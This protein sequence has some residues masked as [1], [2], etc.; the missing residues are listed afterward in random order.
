M[1]DLLTALAGAVILVL[2]AALALPPF[3][4]WTARRAFVDRAVSRSLGMAA[5]SEGEIAVR[6]LPSP[7]LR[8]DRLVLGQEGSL[9]LDARFVKAEVALTPLLKGEFRFT[10]T[11][12]GRAELTV[13]VTEGNALALPPDLAEGTRRDLV[14]EDLQVQQ[15]AVTTQVPAT[16]RTDQIRAEDVHLK[17]PALS[18]P[19]Q[20]EGSSNGTPFRVATGALG[21]DGSLTAKVTG[22]GETRPRFEADARFSLRPV[23]GAAEGVAM[24]EAEGS[25]R[26]VVGPPSQIAGPYLPFSLTGKF[27]ARGPVARFETVAA[28]IDPGGR[29]MRLSGTGQIDLRTWRAGLNLEARRLDI[30]GFLISSA[31]QAWLARGLPKTGLALPVLLDL[32][33]A[34]DSVAL[35]LEEWSGLALKGTFDRGGGLVLRR[36]TATGPGGARLDASGEA[37]LAQALRFSGHLDVEAVNSANLGRFL[38]RA[39][40]P[41]TLANLLDGRTLGLATD[42]SLAG[43]D[44]SLSNLRL[45]LGDLRLAGNARYAAGAPNGRGR[46]EAQISAHGL[47]IAEL[48]SLGALRAGLRRSDLGLTIQARDVRYGPTGSG[49]GRIAARIQSDGTALVVDSL[50][51]TDLAGASARLSGRIAPDGSGRIAGH[52]AAPAAAPLLALVDRFGIPEMRLL[53]NVLRESPLD[54]DLT[55][56]RAAGDTDSL[57]IAAKGK[58]ARG[59]LDGAA[60]SR[61]GRI[62]SAEIDAATPRASDWFGRDDI[63]ALRQPGRLRIA[64]RRVPDAPPAPGAPKPE[65]AGLLGLSLGGNLAGLALST[66]RPILLADD[67]SAPENGTIGIET[68]DLTPFLTLAGS[69]LALS[70]PLR[71]KLTLALS[72]KERDARADLSGRVAGVPLSASLSRSYDGALTG[73]ASL[74]RLSLPLLAAALILPT[75]PGAA[76][77][78]AGWSTARFAAPPPTPRMA[79]DLQVG[80]LDLGRGLTARNGTFHLAHEGETLTLRD[81]SAD[82][83]GGKLSGGL[84]L[85]PLPKGASL[86]GEATLT[87]AALPDLVGEGPLKG[88][89]SGDLRFSS[90]GESPAALVGNLAGE[91][92]LTLA[93]LSLPGADPAAIDRTLARAL[94]EDDPLREG[95]LQGLLAEELSAGALTQAEP[96]TTST[97]LVGGSLRSAPLTLALGPARW[98]GTLGIDLRSRRLDARGTLVSAGAPKGWPGAAPAIQ[99]GFAGPL[100]APERQTDPAPLT[101]GLAAL[102]L[103]RELEKIEMF[104]ADQVERQRRRA[105]IEM[106][107]ARAAALKAAA[108]KEAAEKAAQD[109]AAQERAAQ[110]KAAQEKAAQEDAARRARQAAA[111]EAARQARQR[112]DEEAR[113]AAAPSA[114]NPAEPTTSEPAPQP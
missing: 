64:A 88:R 55:L 82:L 65:G 80:E 43:A 96:V 12:V 47:D 24:P 72:R 6:L 105:R 113:R 5:R 85:M 95:R 30:D 45:S 38:N 25:A 98:T 110:E 60:L 17:A 89:V 44:L 102:V 99:L 112:E 31:G 39:G 13:P 10:E 77:D 69:A 40:G 86:S 83:A 68:P 29:T 114:H 8:L 22:G 104:E 48:P 111:E 28:E 66:D 52:V 26:L 59:S 73:R 91:G 93:G 57:R 14:I 2:V 63:V 107:R 108:E 27:K 23:P 58:A 20:V 75:D 78:A 7:R 3:I 84:R 11:R 41:E 32:E 101:N 94:G 9:S 62:E 34:V 100:T 50:D 70:A 97:T 109:K 79:F 56:E 16:G 74:G 53:P 21:P 35:G 51:V 18:G 67:L 15:L 42:L 92:R 1:R 87:E 37:D 61:A 49:N 103:Q 90:T 36:L 71:A 19:W 46:L 81:L 4:D 106:D 33:L 76:T 54:L